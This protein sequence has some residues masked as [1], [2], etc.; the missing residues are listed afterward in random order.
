[1]ARWW[2][3]RQISLSVARMIDEGRAPSIESAIGKD[4]GTA[5]E[6]RLID[7]LQQLVELE[8]SLGSDSQFQRL[9][10]RAILVSPSWTL[11]GGT[12]E[13]LAGIIAKGIR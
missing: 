3:I 4:L 8:P 5:F 1:M 7:E 9:L 2:G 10:A 12:N 13:I 11:R 6:Q